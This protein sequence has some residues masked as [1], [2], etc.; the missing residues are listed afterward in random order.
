M[1]AV[2]LAQISHRF[3]ENAFLPYSVGR[4][5][6]AVPEDLRDHYR[7]AELLWQ[8]E[9]IPLV[10]E[11][12]AAD[13][14]DVLGIS[15]YIWNERY[16]LAL[17][18][19]VAERF[20]GVCVIAGGPQVPEQPSR[21]AMWL[22]A[23]PSVSVAVIQ[24]GERAFVELL[25]QRLAGLPLVPPEGRIPDLL[26]LGSPYLS[27]VFDE[28]LAIKGVAW[29][30][31]Q[32][33]HRGC[34]FKCHFCNWGSA[35]YSA[36]R[37]FP[38]DMVTAEIAWCGEHGIDLLYNADANF[39]MLKRDPEIA[40]ALIETK[41]RHGAPSKFRAAW[42]KKTTSRLFQIGRDL[43]D[44]GLCKGVTL[45]VQSMD[46]GV[47]RA[48]E[49]RN[50]PY[51]EFARLVR[52]YRAAGVPTYTEVILGLPAETYPSFTDGV[53]RIFEAGQHDGL[54]IYPLIMLENSEMAAPAY[55][56][57]WGL[58]T[59]ELPMLLL[60]GNAQQSDPHEE[61]YQLVIETSTLAHAGWRRAMLFGWVAQGLHCLGLTQDAAIAAHADGRSYAQIYE[62]AL[63]WALAHPDTVLGEAVS[64]AEALLDDVLAGRDTWNRAV[65]HLGPITWPPEELLFLRCTQQI[66]RFYAEIATGLGLAPAPLARTRETLRLPEDYGGDLES[67]AREVVWYGRKGGER[68]KEAA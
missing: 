55:R 11:R 38:I 65:A 57:R 31:V 19:A 59:V 21:R 61:R 18:A 25:R 41:R 3:G 29:Q 32:E 43:A 42:G 14:P 52:D 15:L 60:H 63:A 16:S 48:V 49:R 39:A 2:Y 47:L 67:W 54:N 1:K 64:R 66:D 35:V 51:E 27:G 24:E 34:P 30:A 7:L 10:L 62:S 45:S 28:L 5:W 23:S 12:M 20:P 44:A 22:E 40:A 17:A 68:R 26:A 58:R 46:S 50:T 37:E 8:R 4:L 33:T 56:E 13:P 6:A 36:V 9:P 53:S